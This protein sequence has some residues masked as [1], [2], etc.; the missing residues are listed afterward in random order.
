MKCYR[1]RS[2][3][4]LLLC[5]VIF[6]A[7]GCKSVPK[8]VADNGHL[9]VKGT[10]SYVEKT[11]PPRPYWVEV[12]LVELRRNGS[13]NRI[14]AKMMVESPRQ[15]PVPYALRIEKQKI[16]LKK[17]YGLI[18]RILVDFDKIMWENATP[19]PAIVKGSAK[20]I[21]I[22]VERVQKRR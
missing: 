8:E 13:P 15:V 19:E 6:T 20:S 2:L 12:E 14:V 7:A 5:G 4:G 17:N 18:A 11:E 9:V 21:D 10:V 1:N 22:V 3:A 16:D